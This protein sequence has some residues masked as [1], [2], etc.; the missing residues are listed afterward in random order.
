MRGQPDVDE[1]LRDSVEAY[2]AA[3]PRGG[4]PVYLGL[5]FVLA[6]GFA[7]LPVVRVDVTARAR[8]LL[9]PAIERHRIAA[10]TAGVVEEVLGRRGQTV[11]AQEVLVSL[12]SSDVSAQLTAADSTT[13]DLRTRASDLAQLIRLAGELVDG[14]DRRATPARVRLGRYRAEAARVRHEWADLRAE[15]GA[16]R[17]EAAR[18]SALARLG[19]AAPAELERA[20]LLSERAAAAPALLAERQRTAWAAELQEA[21]SELRRTESQKAELLAGAAL[22]RIR[23]PVA[24]TVEELS[25]ISAGSWVAAGQ[26]IAIVSPRAPLVAEVYVD[27]RDVGRIHP[28]MPVRLLVDAFD[29]HQWGTLPARVAEIADDYTVAQ[30]RP[31]FRIRC[32]LRRTDL[33]ARHRQATPSKGMALTAAFVLGRRSVLHL[34]WDSVTTGPDETPATGQPGSGE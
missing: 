21:L 23:S 7:A 22:R 28:G 9:R 1:L 4:R 18:A 32:A 14:R 27:S 25:P 5:L 20:Q 15:A 2:F 16:A 33:R 3:T 31:M 8:G 10:G 24:G 30:G 11:R 19:L 6:A 34:L 12:E 17:T 29:H 13:T 26:E